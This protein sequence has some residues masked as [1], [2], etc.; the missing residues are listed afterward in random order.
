L[1]T[2]GGRPLKIAHCPSANLKLGSGVA[3][4]PFLRAQANLAVG[5]G[6]DGAPCNND[7][8]VLEEMR[9][10]ALLQ[11]LKGGPGSF[12]ALSALEL[13]TID[14]ARAVGWEDTIGSLEAGKAGDVVVLDLDRPQTFGAP[15]ASI[16]DR[17]V[18]AAAR[19][20]V[21]WVVVDGEIRVENGRLPHLD[22]EEYMRRPAEAIRELLSRVELR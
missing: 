21:R 6:C 19:D 11:G 12:S 18:Y 7:M 9:L 3:D 1:E 17:I 13:A 20:A 8:D 4:L 2:L 22:P 14:G 15:G 10:A 16:Y 5:I